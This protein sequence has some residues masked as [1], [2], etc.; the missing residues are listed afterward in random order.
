MRVASSN[1]R[2][3][4][5]FTALWLVITAL[6]AY[7]TYPLVTDSFAASVTANPFWNVAASGAPDAPFTVTPTGRLLA[8][9]LWP[10]AGLCLLSLRSRFVQRHRTARILSL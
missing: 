8:A 6:L 4:L 2:A 5:V 3:L 10:V 9:A 7:L 1:R